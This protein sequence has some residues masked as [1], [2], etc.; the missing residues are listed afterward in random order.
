[1][2]NNDAEEGNVTPPHLKHCTSETVPGKSFITR[3][4]Y[5]GV[6]QPS[7][8]GSGDSRPVAGLAYRPLT[9]LAC[10]YSTP[11]PA[12]K[13]WRYKQVTLAAAWLTRQYGLTVFSPIT[14]SHPMHTIGKCEGDWKFWEKIDRNYLAVSKELIILMLEGWD[15]SVGL[16]AE[17][18]LAM[19]AGIPVHYLC[20]TDTGY[21]AVES[22]AGYLPRRFSPAQQS[23]Q[24]IQGA[25]SPVRTF[26]TGATRNTEDGKPDFEGFLSPLSLA[27]FGRYM[28]SHQ[29]QADGKLRDSDNWQ[30]GIPKSAYMKSLWRHLVAVWT[31]HRG[32]PMPPDEQGRP[33]TLETA[34][35]AI[36]FNAQG[37]LHEHL[38]KPV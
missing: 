36:M 18:A 8:I 24:V 33:V 22:P 38:K 25:S 16:V 9:Y 10:P 3:P 28:A 30:K 1:M 19:S 6:E 37:Y 27:E 21:V 11:D 26:E 5:P 4:E 14:H 15:K 2:E 23:A 20:P 32:F 29:K 35:S 12:E 7:G 31:L 13:E 17:Q 34:L